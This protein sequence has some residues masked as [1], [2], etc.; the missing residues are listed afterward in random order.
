MQRRKVLSNIGRA[1]T[2]GCAVAAGFFP[3]RTWSQE[4]R[5]VKVGVLNSLSEAPT[6][7]AMEEG[8][9]KEEGLAIEVV[10]FTNTADMVAPL[11]TGQLDVASGAPTLGFLNGAVRGLPF[12]LVADKGRNSPGHGFNA[13]VVRQDLMESGKVKTV[14]DLKGLKVASPSRH[15]PMEIQLDLALQKQG[16]GLD[17][18]SI[19]QLRFPDMLTALTNKAIDAALLIEP[20]VGIASARTIARRLVGADE[21]Y[22]DFQIAGVIYGPEFGAKRPDD[23]KKWMV[24]YLRGIRAYLD[25]TRS[26][27]PGENLV[28]A[29]M[30]HSTAIT[31]PKLL[32]RVVMP[33]F[34][35]DG[36]L[37]LQTIKDSID[38]YARANLLRSKPK[39]SDLVDYQYVDYAL[40]RLGRKGPEQS[41]Q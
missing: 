18:V 8:F 12:K 30:K 4:R 15:S 27:I 10:R 32:E 33:G 35:P 20:F 38:W 5:T 40:G 41:V 23:A 24:G 16:L 26:K 31:D 37:H 1:A 11:S 2:A 29:L 13:I 17:D 6:F 14:A 22:P 39:L 28:Q 3:F 21:I 36:Y 34:S 9:F 25:A 19:E 7:M